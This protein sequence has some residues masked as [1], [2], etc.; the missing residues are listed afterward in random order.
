MQAPATRFEAFTL[1]HAALIA[2]FLAVCVGLALLGRSHRG[3][4]AEVRF[5]RGF[6]L[7]IPCFTVPMQV[8]QL[9]PDDYDIDTSLPLQLCDLAWVAAMVALWTRHWMATALVYFWGLTLTVQGILT[10]SLTQVF[11]DPRYVM[12]WGM[13][14]LTVWAAVYLTFGVR[15]PLTWRSYRFTVACTLVWAATVMVFNAITGTNYGYLNRK[16]AV[17]SLLDLLG[18][19]PGYVVVE[20]VVVAA[21]WALMTWPWTRAS[22][23]AV[24]PE[25]GIRA[26]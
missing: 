14:F 4:V 9:L 16:P 21:V 18:P 17:G 5:R 11:P 1:E 6:A 20:I 12:F 22:R 3:T 23:S 24:V 25:A 19:W 13:H 15:V 26:G 10:P 7:L 2:G 8:L